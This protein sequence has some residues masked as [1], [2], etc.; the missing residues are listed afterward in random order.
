MV[1]SCLGLWFAYAA[2][3]FTIVASYVVNDHRGSNDISLDFD[4]LER[5][6]HTDNLIKE[7]KKIAQTS[8]DCGVREVPKLRRK[9]ISNQ[10]ITCNDG[11]PAG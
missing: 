7:L 11:S 4:Q 10:T 2:C 3:M 5:L 8:H 1:F 9:F 6:G